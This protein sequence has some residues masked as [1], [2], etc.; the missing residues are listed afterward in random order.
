MALAA[1]EDKVTVITALK[2]EPGPAE[3]DDTVAAAV[4]AAFM[5]ATAAFAELLMV[6][7]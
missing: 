7:R 5:A 1:A 4:A 2:L 3:M 6:D